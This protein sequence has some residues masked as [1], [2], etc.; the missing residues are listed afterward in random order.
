MNT[1]FG[2]LSTLGTSLMHIFFLQSFVGNIMTFITGP[3]VLGP[4]QCTLVR[5]HEISSGHKDR[6]VIAPMTF[7]DNSRLFILK[8]D[9]LRVPPEIFLA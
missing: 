2:T 4:A 3:T 5:F 1:P 9:F 7:R 6:F 8:N